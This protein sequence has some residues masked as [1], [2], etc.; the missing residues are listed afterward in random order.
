MKKKAPDLAAVS[1]LRFPEQFS[2]PILIMHGKL[3]LRVPV[4][5]SRSMADKLKS[6]GKAHRYVEQ[7]LGDHHFSRTED[8]LQ[9]LMEMDS[10]LNTHNPAG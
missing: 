5:Q 7:P 3:D 6:A 8:R 2:S 1:P 10:F 4:S 9:F